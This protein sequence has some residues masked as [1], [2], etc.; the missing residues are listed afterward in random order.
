MVAKFI[1]SINKDTLIKYYEDVDF[2]YK[3]DSWELIDKFKVYEKL[4]KV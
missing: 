1:K 3:D 4:T 2:S